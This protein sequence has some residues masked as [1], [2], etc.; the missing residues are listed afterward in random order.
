LPGFAPAGEVAPWRV[1]KGAT[2]VV[3]AKGPNNGRALRDASCTSDAPS[4]LIGEDGR[5]PEEGGPT[6]FAQTRPA[7]CY[8]RLSLG[9]GSRRRTMEDEHFSDPR[10]REELYILYDPR[11]N[12]R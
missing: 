2:V 12:G 1:P 8:E 9:P 7:A 6:R 11:R 3:E 5:V 4:G 10:R